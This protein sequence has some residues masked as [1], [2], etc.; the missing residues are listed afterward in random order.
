M[1]LVL[2]TFAP[3]VQEA[4]EYMKLLGTHQ[5]HGR[6]FARLAYDSNQVRV[7]S[8]KPELAQNL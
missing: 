8:P 1:M 6:V 2:T 4:E 7:L 3:C 5:Q